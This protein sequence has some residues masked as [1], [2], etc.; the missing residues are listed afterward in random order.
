MD[1]VNLKN[2][3]IDGFAALLHSFK[4]REIC[5]RARSHLFDYLPS[6][7]CLL[8]L[9]NILYCFGATEGVSQW[10]FDHTRWR[11][12]DNAPAE[13]NC[14]AQTPDGLLW[15][16][17]PEGL[18]RFDGVGFEQFKS[19]GMVA[20]IGAS[21]STLYA[22]RDGDLWV[23]LRRGGVLRIDHKSVESLSET[24]GLPQT[25]SVLRF[26]EDVDGVLWA[27]TW[28]GIF[29]FIGGKWNRVG[30]EFGYDA[31]SAQEVGLDEAGTLWVLT[32]EN[33]EYLPPHG[34]RFVAAGPQRSQS[35]FVYRQ[36]GRIVLTQRQVTGTSSLGG[37]RSLP[38]FGASDDRSKA[39]LLDSTGW[40]WVMS[41]GEGVY[42]F[43]NSD[44]TP[45][46]HRDG[47]GVQR[48]TTADGLSSDVMYAAFEDREGNIWIGTET[49]VDRFTPSR[50]EV[51]SG[52][53]G[54]F[55][56]TLVAG[57][58]GSVLLT[59]YNRPTLR[60]DPNGTIAE[61][62]STGTDISAS[63]RDPT[64][65]LWFGSRLGI[66]RRDGSRATK[67]P[68][69]APLANPLDDVLAM[70]MD[71]QGRLWASIAHEGVFLLSKGA[72]AP[73][74]CPFDPA[75]I[76]AS[77]MYTDA[78][79]RVWLGYDGHIVKV[80]PCCSPSVKFDV[81]VGEVT[82]LT[83][84]NGTIWA[85][86][87]AGLAFF[88]NGSFHRI[89]MP[90]GEEVRRV[91]GLVF[92][93]SGDLWANGNPGV[94]FIAKSQLG[95]LQN[96]ANYEPHYEV[97]DLMAMVTGRTPPAG[98]ALRDDDGHL[99]FLIANQVFFLRTD[100][101]LQSNFSPPDV[102]IRA[103]HATG[104]AD[105][106]S[107]SVVLPAGTTSLRIAYAA[108]TL[109]SS[110]DI[111]FRYRMDG[112]DTQWQNAGGQREV[113]YMSL[114]PGKYRFVVSASRPGGPWSKGS[115]MD[116]L[117]EPSFTQTRLFLTL[118]V[119]AV[120]SLIYLLYSLRLRQIRAAYQIRT[121]AQVAERERIARELHDTLLQGIQGLTLRLGSLLKHVSPSGTLYRDLEHTIER[122]EAM[123]IEGRRRV[124]DLR[125]GILSTGIAPALE[126][127]GQQLAAD[128]GLSYSQSVNGEMPLDSAIQEEIYG[129]ARE[130]LVNA[131]K[132][133]GGTSVHSEIVFST[134]FFDL[135]ISDD[136]CGI[137]QK[138][139][140]GSGTTDH[141][142]ILGMKER[143]LG[144]G[145]I[146]H[147]ENRDSSGVAVQ[148]QVPSRIA[149]RQNRGFKFWK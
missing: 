115:S 85:G 117:V 125:G 142:G 34:R 65:A 6:L 145:A 124:R 24:K 46:F 55:R 78:S 149:Y 109:I 116:L 53:P 81:D 17:S 12:R 57:D 84:D 8:I 4:S 100:R 127:E 30:E 48:F 122:T 67:I 143:A 49:G 51:I 2:C 134:K 141:W 13:A 118:C 52:L 83:E 44:R 137:D 20:P 25:A 45:A 1:S 147:I 119:F 112:L 73:F 39:Y 136:G 123:V 99:W 14:F 139:L 77:T 148:I 80:E 102:L 144:I 76:S 113:S 58:G 18:F 135:T 91:K 82:A 87:D 79:G 105:P 90:N 27:A 71:A 7:V 104:V 32:G 89:R 36:D 33:L 41:D 103:I 132:H 10:Q 22:S 72:W 131:F 120:A 94:V 60:V 111:V 129:V 133:S 70:T 138:I 110:D 40:V 96:D 74:L 29:R 15:V 28:G 93:P 108:K 63:Y 43:K 128:Y 42:R 86:G 54:S 69:P 26:A 9:S 59:S 61:F 106:K 31:R 121:T 21:I 23:G 146:L 5:V 140:E 114:P 92:S 56:Q 35:G 95:R 75:P 38:Y 19:E 16:G 64:K 47:T 97:F 62:R 11:G 130:A 50:F 126:Q 88:R 101:P 68:L 107:N 66:V 98:G 3:R 37:L